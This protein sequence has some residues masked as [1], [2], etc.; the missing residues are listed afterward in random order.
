MKEG[1]ESRRQFFKDAGAVVAAIVLTSCGQHKET[2]VPAGRPTKTPFQPKSPTPTFPGPT[3][4][5]TDTPQP[6]GTYTP[7]GTGTEAQTP[8][9]TPDILTPEKI[10]FLATH[11]IKHGDLTKKNIMMTY[12]D[13]YVIGNTNEEIGKLLDV[14]KK[15]GFHTSFFII[16]NILDQYK[17]LLPRIAGEGHIIGCHS[18]DH[19]EMPPLTDKQVD[20]QFEKWLDKLNQLL[21]GY[22]TRYWRAPGGSVTK[23]LFEMG[24]KYGMQHVIWNEESGGTTPLTKDYVFNN[25]D[26][27]CKNY[28]A[29]GGSIV[30]SHTQRWYDLNKAESILNQWTSMG[31]TCVNIF[32]GIAASD[33]WPPVS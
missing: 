13:G 29:V 30:L 28:Q 12:D 9:P 23:H 24:A 2:E 1:L 22:T 25:F 27:F 20:E 11:P 26:I 32:E 16:G 10:N 4:K 15:Y 5:P 21:P 14:Y 18:W 3:D 19:S 33:R 8:T 17:D 31:Y 7:T 6:P